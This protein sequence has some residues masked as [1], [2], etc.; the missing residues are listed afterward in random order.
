MALKIDGYC[1]ITEVLTG[2]RRN[3]C[4][5]RTLKRRSSP[6][7]RLYSFLK[8]LF[9]SFDR[10]QLLQQQKLIWFMLGQRFLPFQVLLPFPVDSEGLSWLSWSWRNFCFEGGK[11]NSRRYMRSRNHLRAKPLQSNPQ[12]SQNMF[13]YRA[14]LKKSLS[15]A[16]C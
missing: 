11:N 14:Y 10:S 13:A 2:I 16:D 15:S 12:S 5:S 6:I 8:N 7:Q 3:R 1:W 4:T 9:S